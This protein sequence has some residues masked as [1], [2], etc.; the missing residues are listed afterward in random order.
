M[1]YRKLTLVTSPS[2]S[3]EAERKP[4]LDLLRGHPST[5]LLPV[6]AIY[7]AAGVALNSPSLLPHDS[8]AE[9]RHPLAYGA[10]NGNANVRE[11]IGRWCAERYRLRDAIPL[12]VPSPPRPIHCCGD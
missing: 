1:A 9:N 8:Y 11:E 7:E 12:Y 5:S 6:H 2:N 3:S 4:H 10:D